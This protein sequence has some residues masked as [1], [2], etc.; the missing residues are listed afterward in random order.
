MRFIFF[1]KGDKKE[2]SSRYRAYYLAEALNALG[3]EASVVPVTARGVSSFFSYLKQLLKIAPNEVIVLQRTVYNK[4]F[5]LAVLVAYAFGWRFVFDIDDA[6]YE[7][8]PLQSTT[9]AR[10]ARTV[11]CG[12]EHI[13]KWAQKQ[14]RSAHLLLNGLPLSIYTVRQHEPSEL[15]I[16]WIGNAPPQY[17]SVALLPP[18]LGALYERGY[19]FRFKLVGALGDTRIHDFF[20]D[21]PFPVGIVDTLN[22]SDPREAVAHI[23]TFTVGVMPLT[24]TSWNQAKY[25]KAL[26][27]MA[28]GV[29]VVA[30]ATDTLTR[31]FTEAGCGVLAHTR[32][33]WLETLENLIKNQA[34]RVEEGNKSRRYI[35]KDLSSEKMAHN[36]ISLI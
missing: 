28:C 13:M 2:A 26:E 16:G 32:T 15:T 19:P 23:H 25:F 34:L 12:S 17:E 21:V 18:I 5:F 6:V 36:L 8:S 4:Y 14:N 3:H 33:E 10:L 9:L 24:E 22:W 29:P 7:H 27:Y 35:E 30:S 1:S 11:T 20:K 31:I